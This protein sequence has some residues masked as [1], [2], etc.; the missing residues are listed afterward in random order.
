VYRCGRWYSM[1]LLII[2]APGERPETGAARH[3]ALLFQA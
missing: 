3:G 1:L 2:R